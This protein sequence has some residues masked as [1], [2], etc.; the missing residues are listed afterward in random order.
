MVTAMGRGKTSRGTEKCHK[1]TILV[2]SVETMLVISTA[3]Q[4]Q[5]CALNHQRNGYSE[6]LNRLPLIQ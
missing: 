5:Y 6:F 3:L 1:F 4:A 2:N